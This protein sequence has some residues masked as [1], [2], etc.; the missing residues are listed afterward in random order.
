MDEIKEE[1]KLEEKELGMEID[2]SG[3]YIEKGL[4][5]PKLRS[6][7]GRCGD[8]EKQQLAW[9]LYVESWRQGNPNIIQA[10][11]DA[12]YTEATAQNMGS[13]K[14]FKD[15][16]D[17]LRRSV[18]LT[19]AE[20][21]LSK[22]LDLDYSKIKIMPDG[23]QVEAVDTDTLRIVADISKTVAT[24]LGKDL[25]YSTKT[26]VG[27]KVESEIKINSISYADKPIEVEAKV[28][29]DEIANTQER[30]IEEV[31]KDNDK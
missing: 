14:W 21:N 15:K 9:E 18:M 16:K 31:I 23:S 7:N 13:F 27:G 25:G 8:P 22:I 11:R 24:T 28:V 5:P 26:E 3:L 6:P 12:G 4:V 20:K 1:T 10:G 2:D 29:V 17:K 19:K 30:I